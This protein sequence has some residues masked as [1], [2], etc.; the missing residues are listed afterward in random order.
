MISNNKIVEAS[1]TRVPSPITIRTQLE[2]LF[3]RIDGVAG[4]VDL[5]EKE[6]IPILSPD[7]PKCGKEGDQGP[8]TVPLIA[9]LNRAISLVDEIGNRVQNIQNRIRL[10]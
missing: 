9:D 2:Q 7:E 10:S 1:P 8:S 6:L 3:A 4:A 5:L